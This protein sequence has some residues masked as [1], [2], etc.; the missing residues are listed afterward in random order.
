MN[1][2][3]Y[4]F[5]LSVLIFSTLPVFAITP[6]RFRNLPQANRCSTCNAYKQPECAHREMIV[7]AAYMGEDDRIAL[8][9]A[10]FRELGFSLGEFAQ[11]MACTGYIYCPGKNKPAGGMQSAGA[12]C[13]PGHRSASGYCAPDRLATAGH[14][15]IDKAT[16]SFISD[17]EQ[18][19]FVNYRGHVSLLEVSDLNTIDPSKENLNPL[20]SLRNDKVVVRL[21]NPIVGCNP[22]DIDSSNEAPQ[23]NEILT[24]ITFPHADQS[25]SEFPGTNPLGY[26]CAATKRFPAEG[27]GPALFY[28]SCDLNKVGS[29]GF[30]LGRRSSDGK[31]VVR[32]IFT[33]TAEASL[34]GKPYDD[35]KDAE[36]GN[37]TMA[38]GTGADFVKLAQEP[39]VV[40]RPHIRLTDGPT[41]IQPASN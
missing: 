16:D 5:L 24:A 9:A 15:F 11:A 20:R 1:K 22:Y 35:S 17:L 12:I 3:T 2:A 10:N 37:Y 19:E 23:T 26:N 31:L 40:P 33:K 38:I 7:K 21:K 25:E 14:L 30:L 18:C 28:N 39:G 29:G 34:N 41:N 27:G 32:G 36:E 4:Q 13:A 6:V 8:T